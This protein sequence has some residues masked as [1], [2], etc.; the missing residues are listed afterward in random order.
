MNNMTFLMRNMS[1]GG[2][3]LEINRSRT[4]TAATKDRNMIDGRG[5]A[6]LAFDGTNRT[7]ESY[8]FR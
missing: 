5:T 6:N 4:V 2:C 1:G 8:E 3:D 7:I